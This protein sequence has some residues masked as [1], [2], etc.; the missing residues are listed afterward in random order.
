[1]IKAFISAVAIMFATVSAFAA[2]VNGELA[3]AFTGLTMN[4]KTISLADFK[5]KPVVLE[6]TN[7]E[8][9][10][11]G[12]HY[13]SGNMQKTQRALTEDG[14]VWIS[15]ASSAPGKHGYI[16][17]E[18]AKELTVSRG[19]YTDY[20]I[21]DP[22]GTIGRLY[23]AKT[24]PHMFLINEEGILVYQGAIDDIPSASARSLAKATNLVLAAWNEMKTG[25]PISEP[26]TSAYGCAIKY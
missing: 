6:W 18:L 1:M 26:D 11:V 8:C 16:T 23:N 21:L 2:P 20:F 15:I 12:K 22:E 25:Q 3:P 4:G 10:Y 13:N 7:H 17:A 19:S 14:V 24:T 5:G 9:P